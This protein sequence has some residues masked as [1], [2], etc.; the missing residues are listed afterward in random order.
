[1]AGRTV[2]YVPVTFEDIAL[3]NQLAPEILGRSLD[4]LPPQTRRLLD[5]VRELVKD[6]KEPLFTRKEL[7]EKCGWSLTQVRVHLDRLVELEYLYLRTGRMG[8]PFEYE[9]ALDLNGTPEET[10]KLAHIGLIDVD[11]L[12]KAYE[13]KPLPYTYN[14]QVA[15]FSAQVAEKTTPLT[16][17]DEMGPPPNT[18]SQKA[19]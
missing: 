14:T 6:R 7:R 19:A 17:G 11:E 5:Y 16:G 9:L 10:A 12:R 18:S 4:E 8:G 1:V 2:N 15:G 3:A 13:D